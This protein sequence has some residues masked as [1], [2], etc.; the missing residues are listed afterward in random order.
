VRDSIGRETLL[1]RSLGYDDAH[2]PAPVRLT[3]AAL[4]C[5]A[6]KRLNAAA[7]RVSVAA[8]IRAISVTFR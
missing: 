7:A 5:T 1:R 4:L 8:P 2:P 3:P 6:D